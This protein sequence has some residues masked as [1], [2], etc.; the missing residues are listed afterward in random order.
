M[1]SGS[2]RFSPMFRL[3]IPKPGKPGK[4]RPITQ[5]YK[6]DILVMDAMAMVLNEVFESIF[7]DCSHGFRKGRGIRTFF[8]QVESW[9]EVNFIMKADFVGCFD[10]INHDLLL[11]VLRIYISDSAFIDLI[12]RFLQADIGDK[13]G[14]SY[15]AI[16]KGIPQGSS[17]SPVLMNL[18]CHQ[19][20]LR[21]TNSSPYL[22]YVRYA[23]DFLIAIQ[24]GFPETIDALL[25]WIEKWLESKCK[26][27]IT[28]TIL[29]RRS[30]PSLTLGILLSID[31]NGI[32]H[33]KAPLRRITRKIEN[34]WKDRKKKAGTHS[35]QEPEDID[36]LTKYYNNQIKTYLSLYTCCENA[37]AIQA[38]LKGRLLASYKRDLA[39][40][41]QNSRKSSCRPKVKGKKGEARLLSFKE[42][43]NLFSK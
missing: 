2:F 6:D 14:R 18:F 20:D 36:K 27:S 31:E 13:D 38:F 17:L 10:N 30:Q 3:F 19:L 32:P 35:C 22:R 8:A 16:D 33:L 24:P 23:D 21:I 39:L 1:K 9:G 34:A 4:M 5:P 11:S 15:A 12:A 42:I 7:L 40:L 28:N 37:P 29:T 43:H 41:N 26:L 25:C